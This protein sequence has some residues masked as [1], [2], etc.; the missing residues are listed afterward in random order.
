VEALPQLR[1]LK[2][3]IFLLNFQQKCRF[4][5]F[6]WIK[7]KLTTFAPM[8]NFTT[9]ATP[10]KMEFN[11]FSPATTF[12]PPFSFWLLLEKVTIAPPWKNPCGAHGQ[13]HISWRA[14]SASF[15]VYCCSLSGKLAGTLNASW[16]HL[17]PLSSF[18]QQ[19]ILLNSHSRWCAVEPR[20]GGL[21]ITCL[22]L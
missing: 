21:K 11:H 3:D 22:I 7:W 17:R 14:T 8:K 12:G 10:G 1:I 6:E 15:E 20:N 9:F 2:F 18:N 16:S 19:R 5:S 4:L 13:E